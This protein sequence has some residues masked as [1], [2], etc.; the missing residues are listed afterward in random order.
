MFRDSHEANFP[1]SILTL[2]NL[3]L[4]GFGFRKGTKDPL[5]TA[6]QFDRV[7]CSSVYRVLCQKRHWHMV[8]GNTTGGNLYWNRQSAT[9]FIDA[10]SFSV[11]E[12]AIDRQSAIIGWRDKPFNI[13]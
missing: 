2:Y 6:H 10:R 3:P 4:S 9:L 8:N 1:F 13:N 11:W 7:T 5:I 12:E